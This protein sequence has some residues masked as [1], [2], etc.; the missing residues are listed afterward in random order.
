MAKR[1]ELIMSEE[2][3]DQIDEINNKL[4]TVAQILY[5]IR[6]Q[7]AT[8]IPEPPA[9]EAEKEPEGGPE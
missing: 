2:I 3:Q 9:P 1:A 7:W 4:E 8:V 5:A 6:T